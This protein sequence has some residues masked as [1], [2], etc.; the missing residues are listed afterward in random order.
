MDVRMKVLFGVCAVIIAISTQSVEA[1]RLM[2]LRSAIKYADIIFIGIP[3]KVSPSLAGEGTGPTVERTEQ[4][5]E[6]S[7]KIH[8]VIKGPE[9]TE[10]QIRSTA[11]SC[12]A[13]GYIKKLN[14]SLSGYHLIYATKDKVDGHY[15]T[16]LWFPNGTIPKRIDPRF[17]SV[18]WTANPNRVAVTIYRLSN[19][20]RRYRWGS[21]S[22][23]MQQAGMLLPH[24]DGV[25]W[26]ASS[27]VNP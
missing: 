8:Q 4:K 18:I 27:G 5:Y 24:K 11:H 23:I 2:N 7:F 22:H 19:S 16:N 9:A 17:P 13:F 6:F 12:S 1:C 25:I 21:E 14:P 10:I 20:T 26:P 3:A 15:K